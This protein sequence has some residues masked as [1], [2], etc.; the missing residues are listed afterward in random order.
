MPSTTADA[1]G[2]KGAELVRNLP[3]VELVQACQW[4]TE[5]EELVALEAGLAGLVEKDRLER[6]P[7]LELPR[8]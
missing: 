3:V 8:R 5:I 2:T 1:E 7:F 6:G 4:A